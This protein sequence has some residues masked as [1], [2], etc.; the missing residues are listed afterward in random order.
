MSQF[1]YVVAVFAAATFLVAFCQ[2]PSSALFFAGK[3]NG[4]VTHVVTPAPRPTPKPTPTPKPIH[5]AAPTDVRPVQSKQDCANALSLLA[6]LCDSAVKASTL[7]LIWKDSAAKLTGYKVYRTDGG[8]HL[9]ITLSNGPEPRFAAI[10]KPSGG[11]DHRCYAVSA[12]LG[13][14]ESALSHAYC[15]QSGATA[16]TVT[17]TPAHV[18]SYIAYN[19]PRIADPNNNSGTLSLDT[20]MGDLKSTG[21]ETLVPQQVFNANGSASVNGTAYVGLQSAYFTEKIDMSQF[22]AGYPYGDVM[23]TSRAGMDF[24]LNKLANRK[25]YSAVLTL[26]VSQ[27]VR[28]NSSHNHFVTS[29]YSCADHYWLGRDFWW[30]QNGPLNNVTNGGTF[31]LQSGPTLTLDMTKPVSTWAAAGDQRDYGFIFS[32]ALVDAH[33]KPISA[34]VGCFTKYYTAQLKVIY[35]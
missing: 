10:S 13:N 25:I 20:L 2:R 24:N 32:N 19:K 6:T 7:Q 22:W 9:N 18:R 33:A 23:L 4:G 26:D 5:I 8:R 34:D 27:T 11:Y 35:F 31:S 1:R 16:T 29:D 3:P 21:F 28:D 15:V 17:F 12:Y 14:H 30:S